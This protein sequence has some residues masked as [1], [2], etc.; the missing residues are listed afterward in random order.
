YSLPVVHRPRWAQPPARADQ[1]R[2]QLG[3]LG[4]LRHRPEEDGD[5]QVYVVAAAQTERLGGADEVGGTDLVALVHQRG[6]A[7]LGDRLLQGDLAERVFR[8]AGIVLELPTVHFQ[9]LGAADRVVALHPG[10]QQREQRDHLERRTRRV[11]GEGRRGPALAG[12]SAGGGEHLTGGGP[13]R[14]QR[15]RRLLVGEDLL[16]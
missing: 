12:R 11:L 5:A 16:G 3:A 14:H 1:L 13:D 15:A 2:G 4:L 6:V 7:G 9:R 10:P 8:V